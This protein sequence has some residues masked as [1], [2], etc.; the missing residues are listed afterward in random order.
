MPLPVSLWG[1]FSFEKPH[2]YRKYFFKKIFARILWY[3]AGILQQTT[4]TLE[5]WPSRSQ[6]R[7]RAFHS[8]V[9]LGAN[10]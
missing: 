10:V 3:F 1:T 7:F 6:G 4:Q 5:Q 8:Q 9:V 2:W